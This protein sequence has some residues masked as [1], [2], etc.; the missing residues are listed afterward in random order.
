MA[1]LTSSIDPT[2]ETFQAN[3]AVYD[4]LLKTCMAWV[5]VE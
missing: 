3:T 1:T 5:T 4:G 2:S